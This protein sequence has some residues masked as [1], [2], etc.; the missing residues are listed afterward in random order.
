MTAIQIYVSIADRPSSNSAASSNP[1]E[2]HWCLPPPPSPLLVYF[3]RLVGEGPLSCTPP[4]M[5][6]ASCLDHTI[7]ACRHKC[8]SHAPSCHDSLVL[9]Q[10]RATMKSIVSSFT[11]DHLQ[12]K[13]ITDVSRITDTTGSPITDLIMQCVGLFAY[14]AEGGLGIKEA[15]N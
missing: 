14:R 12:P 3:V 9:L 8:P 10:W 4:L 6:L 5:H 2:C 15:A 1:L 7:S 13:C 11:A